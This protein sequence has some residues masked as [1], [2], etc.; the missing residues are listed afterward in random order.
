MAR[1]TSRR[2]RRNAQCHDLPNPHHDVPGHDLDAGRWKRLVET[3]L[4]Q[5]GI[6]L[7]ERFRLVV[8]EENGEQKCAL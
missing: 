2:L 5:L 4:S 7:L 1:L 6:D 8:L 3:L